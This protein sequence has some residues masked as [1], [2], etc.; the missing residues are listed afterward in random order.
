M[1]TVRRFL[2]A[3]VIVLAYLIGHSTDVHEE[4]TQDARAQ[5]PQDPG[6]AHGG[7]RPGH[8]LVRFNPDASPTEVARLSSNHGATVVGHISGIGVTH[9]LVP[10]EQELAALQDL[11]G[12]PAV[13]FAEF[14]EEVTVLFTPND[15]YY[16]TR[17]PSTHYGQVTQWALPAVSAPAAW[18]TTLGSS[19][20]VIAI[21]DTGV[22]PT[23]PDLASKIIGQRSYVGN[24][25]D[26]FGHGT[27][28]AGIA[29]AATNNKTGVAGACPLC[30]I[31]SVKVLD[32]NGRGSTSD[33]A[34]ALVYAADAGAKVISLS[35][36]GSGQ[37]ET[38]HSAIDY[39]FSHDVLPVCAM[40]NSNNASAT[41]EPAYWFN[42]LSVIATDQS[43]KKASFSNYGVKAD[44]AAPG[45]AIL[46]TMPTYPVTLTT[47][48]GYGENYDAL[49]GT[50]MATPMMAGTAGLVLS[51][52]PNLTRTQ[53]AG[54]LMASTD[55]GS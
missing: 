54:T 47:N 9:L 28:C 32:D 43:G 15:P 34:S 52:N 51:Q 20:T 37:T 50:S 18:D 12:S 3:F 35:L 23:H 33:V 38:M 8:L 16:S 24:T 44:V 14:D 53:V 27:H 5:S 1:R 40:G 11:K 26:G 2:P 19:G 39:A 10:Q 29:A 48:Y 25:T 45:V 21:V 13:E 4:M 42:C 22:D 46:S 30:M 17:Y 7:R 6:R 49:S 55:A 41:P 31:L 36:G